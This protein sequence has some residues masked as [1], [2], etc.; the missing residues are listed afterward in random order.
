[1]RK[2]YLIIAVILILM[3][4]FFRLTL[5]FWVGIMPQCLFLKVTG[6]YCPGCGGTR[7]VVSLL[8]GHIFES[9]KYNPGVV[10][11]CVIICLLLLEKI[12]NKKILPRA[13]SF[14][15]VFIIVLFFYYIIRNL[16]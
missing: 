11:L 6:L 15:V 3:A 9:I 16:F 2:K 8:N 5:N 12:F 7:A 4:V 10:S 13:L 1:M 14:W